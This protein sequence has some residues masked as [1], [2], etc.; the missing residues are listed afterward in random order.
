VWLYVKFS[1]MDAATDTE[2]TRYAD[3]LTWMGENHCLEWP[4][5]ADAPWRSLK[6]NHHALDYKVLALSDYQMREGVKWME[7]NTARKAW[8]QCYVAEIIADVKDVLFIVFCM[9]ISWQAADHIVWHKGILITTGDAT[10]YMV[11]CIAG[12]CFGLRC[13]RRGGCT[14]EAG[15]ISRDL[16]KFL[17][18]CRPDLASKHKV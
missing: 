10:V 17:K 18:K 12:F 16:T 3:A 14:S 8:R 9:W 6:L 7:L 4:E 2:T 13:W 11:A 1:N 5:W 15:R